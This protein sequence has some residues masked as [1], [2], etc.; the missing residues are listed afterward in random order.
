MKVRQPHCI[1]KDEMCI[2]VKSKYE[3]AYKKYKKYKMHCL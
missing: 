2:F 1:A 3:E